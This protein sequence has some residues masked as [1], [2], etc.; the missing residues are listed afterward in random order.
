MQTLENLT[1][2]CP[3]T[4]PH[5]HPTIN[6]T[7]IMSQPHMFHVR[8]KGCSPNDETVVSAC[9]VIWY[10]FCQNT[11]HFQQNAY[12]IPHLYWYIRVH[13]S[14]LLSRGLNSLKTQSGHWDLGPY[15]WRRLKFKYRQLNGWNGCYTFV[16]RW[17][18]SPNR[19]PCIPTFS[20]YLSDENKRG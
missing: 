16:F 11:I 10:H 13:W 14:F 5:N 12:H 3:T 15:A 19:A 8:N 9:F 6:L 7:L 1:Y 2:Q 18:D 17:M 20:S 4:F